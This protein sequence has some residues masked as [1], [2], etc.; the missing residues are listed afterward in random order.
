VPGIEAG[1]SSVWLRGA[2]LVVVSALLLTAWLLRPAGHLSNPQEF[3]A[4]LAPHRFAWY[5]P[6][7][8]ALAFTVLGL[9]LVP[10]LLLIVTTGLVFG[11]LL[12]PIYA[13]A[14]C[15]ASASTGFAIGRW[16]GPGRIKH[17][18][19]E[20]VGRIS[21]V[22]SQNGT[23]AVF[24]LR[25]V[26]APFM[27]AN[28]IAGA[29]TIHFRDFIVGT[30]LGM[31]ALVVGLAGFGYQLTRVLENPSAATLAGAVAVVSVPLA[32]AWLVNRRVRRARQAG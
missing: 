6:P 29:S 5:A 8:V 32:L 20:R 9:A 3:S 10:V 1:A 18:G 22:L 19:G 23:L 24:L 26:P 14:G 13:M 12:G 16:L 4:W 15:L 17:V 28:I 31:G 7:A 30:V 27:L 25:K 2:A 11:P 21:R